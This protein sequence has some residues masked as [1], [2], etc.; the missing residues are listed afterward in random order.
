MPTIKDVAR[1]CGV[2]ANTVSSVLNRKSGEVSESTRERILEAIRRMGYRPNASARRMTGKRLNTIGIADRYQDSTLPE[3]H[4]KSPILEGV[5]HAARRSRWDVLYYS[6]HPTE[7]QVNAFPAYLDGRCDGLICF[8]GSMDEEVGNAIVSTDLPV[9]FI[10]GAPFARECAVV[11][12]DNEAAAF[13][14]VRHLI[15][16]G[17]TR[18]GMMQGLTTAGN[19]ARIAGY[20]RALSTAGLP[21]DETLLYPTFATADS[22]YT[23][24]LTVLSDAGRPTAIFCFH[25]PLAL[26]LMRAARELG[27]A[28]PDELSVVGFDDTIDAERAHPPLTTVR[29]PLRLIGSRAAEILIGIIS[30]DISRNHRETVPHELVVRGSTAPPATRTV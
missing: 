7:E 4:Y 16:L 8:T 24:A 19:E 29:Q 21:F 23:C 18:I 14:A 2:S 5:I 11:D 1:E 22:G 30:G 25:D 27:I 6:G 26:D 28:V 10:A 12:I 20:R 17:H 15:D 3:N 9:V 13:M